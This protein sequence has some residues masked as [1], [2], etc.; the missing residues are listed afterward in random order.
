MPLCVTHTVHALTSRYA[1]VSEMGVIVHPLAAWCASV[2]AL[3]SLYSSLM[4]SDERISR[5]AYRAQWG[6]TTSSSNSNSTG[7]NN[8]GSNSGASSSSGSSS[9]STSV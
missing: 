4:S 7:S 1:G 2:R 5:V 8:S 3:R 9:S 6:E